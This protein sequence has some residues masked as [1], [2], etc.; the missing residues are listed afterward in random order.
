DRVITNLGVL[1][2]TGNG[3]KIIELAPDVSRQDIINATEAN[4]V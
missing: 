4:I 3:L 1:D 2:V